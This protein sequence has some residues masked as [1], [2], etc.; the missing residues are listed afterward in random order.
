MTETEK[1]LQQV[2]VDLGQAMVNLA[3]TRVQLA[4]AQARIEAQAAQIAEFE[5]QAVGKV[6]T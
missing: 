3:I 4:N 2:A 1:I 6:G 5:K